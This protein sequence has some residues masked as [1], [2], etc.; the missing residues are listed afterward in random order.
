MRLAVCLMWVC[1]SMGSAMAKPFV[2]GRLSVTGGVYAEQQIGS[3]TEDALATQAIL[4]F[5]DLRGTL[6]VQGVGK[7][8][9][10]RLDV[11]LRATGSY[12]AEAKFRTFDAPVFGMPP[13]VTAR[14]YLGGPEYDLREAYARV[15]MTQ[16]TQLWV[17]RMFVPEADALKIDGG[18]LTV[19]LGKHWQFGALLGGYPNPYSRSLLTDYTAPCGAGVSSGATPPPDEAAAGMDNRNPVTDENA[20]VPAGPLLSLVFGATAHYEY[21]GLPGGQS[22]HGSLSA[23]GAVAG[24]VGA[25]GPVVVDSGA[26]GAISNLRPSNQD[27]DTGR[28][29]LSWVQQVR[30]NEHVDLFSD[31]VVDLAGSRGVQLTR[32]S[33]VGSLRW[34]RDDRLTLRGSYSYM[35]SLAIDLFMSRFVYNRSPFGTTLGGNGVVENNLTIL[36]IAR[37][38]ARMHAD[39]GLTK[40][41][42]IYTEGRF[43]FRSLINGES[44][45]S[46]YLSDFYLSTQRST[47]FDVTGGLRDSGSLKKMRGTVA[48]TFLSDFRATNHIVRAA[49][50]TDLGQ[51]RLSLDASYA[52]VFTTDAGASESGCASN[53]N[54][55]RNTQPAQL[56]TTQSLFLADCF[57]RRRGALHELGLGLA[58]SPLARQRLFFLLDYRFTA[59]VSESAATVLGHFGLVRV[60]A[61]F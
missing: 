24:G 6:D 8:L 41:L 43:R 42:R 15:Q 37:H 54:V 13:I 10:V 12:D 52:G 14:G 53:L 9:D 4:A 58:L 61:R 26:G 51:D 23:I 48:Y 56:L 30:L 21:L 36:G 2:T 33:L 22:L 25:G 38:E 32:G 20:C 59:L 11:R 46:V 27:N 17:G 55:A 49:L 47:A 3:P 44:N 60:E 5:G 31:V 40:Q 19:Q 1:A 50:G 45:Q 16:R 34:L 57:G 39:F 28:V 7:R 29:Y 35:S 18:R